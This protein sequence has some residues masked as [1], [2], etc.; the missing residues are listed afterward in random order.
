MD[1]ERLAARHKDA[2]YRQ[3]VRACGNP[4][5][6]EDALAEALLRAHQA[7]GSLREPEA[8]QGWLAQIAR[9]VCGRMRRRERL[10]PLLA[11]SALEGEGLEIADPG[12]GLEAELEGKELRS[13]VAEALGALD[14]PYRQAY[15]L[16]DVDGLSG[17]EAAERLG[18][19]LAALKSRLH[20]ARKAVRERL[21]LSLCGE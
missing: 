8:F 11:L 15:L 20:R 13:C 6:A 5:D 17:E 9:R 18:I 4:D 7:M 14:E 19:S 21:D 10:A 2:V 12:P 3:M 16:R 1:F